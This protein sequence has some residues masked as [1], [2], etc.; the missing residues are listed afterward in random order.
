MAVRARDAAS[1]PLPRMTSKRPCGRCA[2]SREAGVAAVDAD[3]EAVI[4]SIL[5]GYLP[6]WSLV[7]VV[8]R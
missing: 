7:Q 8:V 2:K 3:V 6:P 1:L 4:V 5:D